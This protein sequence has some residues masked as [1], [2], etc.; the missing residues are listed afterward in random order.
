MMEDM[1]KILAISAEKADKSEVFFMKNLIDKVTLEGNSLQTI[2]NKEKKG[3]ALRIKEKGKTGFAT[4]T[5]F[6]EKIIENALET[7]EFGEEALFEFAKDKVIFSP[8]NYIN[9]KIDDMNTDDFI[10]K[11][12]KIIDS[13]TSSDKRITV[14]LN[15]E[16]KVQ[17]VCLLTSNGFRGSYRKNYY[18]LSIFATLVRENNFFRVWN[19][20]SDSINTGKEEE[21]VKEIICQME[22]GMNIGKIDGGKV[23]VLFTPGALLCLVLSFGH[24]INGERVAKKISPLWSKKEQQIFDERIT[25]YDDGAMEGLENSLP[26]DDEGIA[27][28]KTLLVDKGVLKNFIVDLK[29]GNILN[30]PPTGNASRRHRF[31]ERRYDNYPVIYPNVMAIEPGKSRKED[32]L[33]DIKEGVF[34]KMA[35]E[36]LT[37]NTENGDFSGRMSQVYKVENGKITGRLRNTIISGNIY[38]LLK[39][40]LVDIS[41]ETEYMFSGKAPYMLF[42][43]VDITG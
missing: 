25:I 14:N 12:E 2:E 38:S 19:G 43:D 41:S 35:A 17:D 15:I 28:G 26:F 34:V 37:G 1:D 32:L 42:K 27:T 16:K 5:V 7:A 9:K 24:G 13:L 23:P 8:E 11:G 29:Y 4:S 30:M 40:K 31:L 33:R 18:S 22:H 36:F 6:D 21:W 20:F 3:L 39:D 10:K